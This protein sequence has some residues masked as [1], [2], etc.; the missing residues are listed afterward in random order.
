MG[1]AREQAVNA[2]AE[3]ATVER[4]TRAAVAYRRASTLLILWGVLV[5]LGSGV[6]QVLPDRSAAI[7]YGTDAIGLVVTV[8]IALRRP[9]RSPAT[10]DSWQ[11]FGIFLVLLT[12]GIAWS[13]LLAPVGHDRL[14]VFWATLMMMGCVIAGLWRGP[15]FAVCGLIGTALSFAAFFLA[16]PWLHLWIGVTYGVGFV[17]GGFWLR[18]LGT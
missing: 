5:A 12:Y 14:A 9:W 1:G 2:L 7:W 3:I 8:A 6:N 17:L 16:G 10:R 13:Y 18:H 15:F 11:I 4:R